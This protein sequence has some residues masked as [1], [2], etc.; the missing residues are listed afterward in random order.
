MEIKLGFTELNIFGDVF[1]VLNIIITFCIDKV[2][3]NLLDV[4]RTANNKLKQLIG[5]TPNICDVIQGFIILHSIGTEIVFTKNEDESFIVSNKPSKKPNRVDGGNFINISSGGL[6]AIYVNIVI[7]VGIGRQLNNDL[8]MEITI[9][10]W[11]TADWGKSFNMLREVIIP[12][13]GIRTDFGI[14]LR[15]PG[16]SENNPFKYSTIIFTDILCKWY[17][18]DVIIINNEFSSEWVKLEN[19]WFVVDNMVTRLIITLDGNE[20]VNKS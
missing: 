2:V 12:S 15:I 13:I 6:S 14:V 7:N 5:I 1:K 4:P 17:W 19:S 18:F 20:L 10:I 3:N 16:D 8:D 11:I 9:I